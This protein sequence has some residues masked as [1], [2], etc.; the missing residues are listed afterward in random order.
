MMRAI[1]SIKCSAG[2][3]ATISCP[4]PA[5]GEGVEENRVSDDRAAYRVIYAVQRADAVYVLP[6]FQTKTQATPKQDIDTAQ[7]RFAQMLRGVK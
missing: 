2:S 3:N 4:M 1:N 7:T 5:I 6:A